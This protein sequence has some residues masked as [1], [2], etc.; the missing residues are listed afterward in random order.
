MPGVAVVL[1]SDLVDS[2][3]LLA[4]LGD[5]RMDRLRRAHVED[6]NKAV[7]A[8]G[9]RVVK[10]LGD[11]VMSS[12][13]SALG[14]LR[15]AAQIQASVAKLDAAHGGI[16]VAARVGVAAGEPIPDGEDLHGMT[17]VIA[18]RLSSAAGTGEVLVQDLVQELVASRDG[19]VLE[20]ARDYELKGVPQPV[21][22]ARL[23]WREL[24]LE[25]EAPVPTEEMVG[26]GTRTSD[27]VRLPPPLA[28]FAEEPLIGREAEVAALRQATQPRPRRRAALILGEPGIGKTRHAAAAALE[29]HARGE[30]VVLA[31]CPPEAVVPFE[32]WVRAIGELAL[33]GDDEW[34]RGLTAAAGAEL[35]ALVP[36]LDR[37]GAGAERVSSSELAAAEGARYRLL[38]GIGTALAHAAGDAP[39]H[40]VLDDAHW[41]DPASAQALEHL[42]DS[43]PGELVLVATARDREMGRR[44]P[45]S[46]ALTNLRRTG[47]LS[48]LRLGGLDASGLAALVGARVGQAITPRVASSL[49]SRTAGNPFF[50][51]ELARDLSEQGALGN[52]EAL[53]GAPVPE[54]VS[55]L[56]EE[57]LGRLEP[58]TERLLVAV[59]AIG[60]SAP[61]WLAAK[62][63][64]LESA[65]AEE[66]VAEALSERLV[67]EVPAPEP[68]IAFPHAL[69]REALIASSEEAVL[70]RLHLAIAEALEAGPEAEPAEI[71]RHYGL[72][73]S[74]TGPEPAIGAYRAA[75][76]A[77]AAA[78]DHEQAAAQLQCA[79]SLLP[80]DD[81]AARAQTLLEL[82]E[83]ALLSADM[84]RAKQAFR[85]AAE[86]ARRSGDK[87]TLAHAALGFAGGDIAFGVEANSHDSEMVDLLR[88]TLDA[89]GE[90]RPKLALKVVFRLSYALT[91]SADKTDLDRLAS[92]AEALGGQLEDPESKLLMRATLLFLRM[93]MGPDPLRVFD[94]TTAAF[95]EAAELAEECDREDLRFRFC[96]WSSTTLYSLRRV[97]ECEAAIERAAEI[98]E[99]LGSPRFA[100][101]I[102][103]Y[104]AQRALDRGD[105][106]RAV[107]LARRAGDTLRRLRPD[108]QVTAELLL[109]LTVGWIYDDEAGPERAVFDAIEALAPWGLMSALTA[110]GAARMGDYAAAGEKMAELLDDLDSLRRPDVHMPPALCFLALAATLAEDREAGA[111]LR[112]LLEPLRGYLVQATP[113]AYLGFLPQWQI[114]RLEL[115]AGATEAAGEELRSAVSQADELGI[116]WLSG[117]AR[118]DLA[119]ALYRLGD[120]LAEAVLVEAEA[121]AERY[122]LGWVRNQA[123]RVRAELEGGEAPG[124]RPPQE[125][126]RPLRA[127]TARG[128]RRALAALVGGQ[129]DAE[130]ERRFLEPKRQRGLLRA[131]AR[132]FQPAQAAGFSGV[133]AYE[134]EPFEVEAPPEAPWRWAIEVDSAA[135]HAKLLEP[136]PLDAAVTIHMGLA[137]WVRVI[138]G[139]DNAI[140]AMAAG[141]CSVEGDVMVAV[142]LEAMFSGA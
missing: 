40:I 80:E 117:A 109:R 125:R 68:T 8:S 115:L 136:A 21:R 142:R 64:G 27:R 132:S 57:R 88:E 75:A 36:Q 10:T 121:I 4:R 123:V 62:A 20:E 19:A 91:F 104:R 52:S 5:D 47:D 92:R 108:L 1:F 85:D 49:A 38:T 51:G 126:P 130:L 25:Q 138:A 78:H 77:A 70:G 101:E 3:G 45:V 59:A 31:R 135:G 98:A 105:R 82:G 99:R 141:R 26:S 106:D 65:E 111:R 50:A 9:G 14:A 133:V 2:T 34:R 112:P 128:G 67:D 63:I 29:A 139:V 124:H 84:Q 73:V 60:P 54:A 129:S 41:C 100:W 140:T 83:Q 97:E 39:L 42:L 7:V 114:G 134:L 87:G 17:V 110:V 95:L 55:Q 32:P 28:A 53:E 131:M 86:L 33:A 46:R 69:V 72:S 23:R 96:L 16:G 119:V 102:D 118:L 22:A 48:E 93:S 13:D 81:L 71:A 122:G 15:A 107:E 43:S 12:F 116:V 127:L 44:H 103:F 113:T 35:T 37:G 66:A 24:A 58:E 18:S 76:R 56:I 30:L 89:L 11:G 137:Q 74:L 120:P 90:D 6:V 61:V 94:Q 79:L